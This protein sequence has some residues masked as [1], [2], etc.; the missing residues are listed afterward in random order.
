M[1]SR[2]ELTVLL[3]P[4]A[5]RPGET[6]EVVA[7]LVSASDTPLDRV[8]FDLAGIERVSFNR[9]RSTVTREY[10]HFHGRAEAPGRPLTPGTHTYHARFELPAALPPPYRGRH[11]SVEYTVEVRADIPWWPDRVGRFSVPVAPAP[12]EAVREPR[13]F[14]S[15]HGGAKGGEL[16]AEISMAS[17]AIEPGGEIAGTVAFTNASQARRVSIAL[18][19][20]ERL[21]A[22]G[23]FFEGGPIRET[24]EVQR[25]SR[26]LC[27]EPPE[28]GRGL[29]FRFEIGPGVVPGYVGAI[30]ALEWAIEVS[31]ERLFGR[32]PVLHAP[33]QVLA[34]AGAARPS[35][36]AVVPAV[37]HERR[38]LSFAHVG[39]GLGLEHDAEHGDLR[40]A[41]GSVWLRVAPESRPDGTPATVAH[42]AWPSL[43][44]GLSIAP[45]SWTDLL[46]REIAVGVADFDRRFH[47]ASRFPEQARALLDAELCA[48]LVTFPEV[49][50]NDEGATLAV[51]VALVDEAPLAEFVARAS[52]AARAL[53]AG[54]ARVP[55]PP[56][57]AGGDEAWRGM[58]ARLGGRFEP[59]RG[60]IH[61]G[62]L[63]QERV[64]I[65]TQWAD[66]GAFQATVVRVPL[67]VRVD[68]EAVSA[69]ARAQA[70]ALGQTSGARVAIVEDAVTLTLDRPVPDPR[71]LDPALE[72][73]GRLVHA[74]RRRDGAGPFRS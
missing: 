10:S 20:F 26:L 55:L 5:P 36:P 8:V 35:P 21:F 2:P 28:E 43:G 23:G 74:V 15:E 18:V 29:P 37:G 73:L 57:L 42:L 54:F 39:Q 25:W 56:P 62:A 30:S 17:T 4:G 14:V 24:L 48:L 50:M 41:L 47:V 66:D 53:D 44:L 1:R 58:A 27:E 16:Y 46:S 22:D 38:A 3:C 67:D 63:D 71:A 52:R 19:A 34:P 49:L 6:L 70:E 9:G 12:V 40:G 32:R 45:S 11:A 59:G 51:P 33:I 7:Q 68:L 69:T 65:I 31:T 13:V 61:D 60:A 72:E 64:E